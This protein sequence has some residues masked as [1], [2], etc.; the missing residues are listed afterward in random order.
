[1][2][3]EF[4]YN[5]IGVRMENFIILLTEGTTTE[6]SLES[7]MSLIDIA[8]AHIKKKP[9]TGYGFDCFKMVSGM[10]GGG[11]VDAHSE[12]YYSHNNYI[13]LLFGGGIIGLVL[14]YIPMVYLLV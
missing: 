7:R 1:M 9:W 14:Y 8:M 2:R 13:E 5:I 11:K 3:V 12:G 4:L 6:G 10:N